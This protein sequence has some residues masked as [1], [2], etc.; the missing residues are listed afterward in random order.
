MGN[1]LN[2]K[3]DFFKKYY[4]TWGRIIISKSLGNDNYYLEILKLDMF[5][6][7][8]D[9][10]GHSVVTK[11]FGQKSNF[12]NSITVAKFKFNGNIIVLGG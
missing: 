7:F 4:Y 1:I 3:K 2:F 11:S 5:A 12:V 10:V 6:K 9:I 8:N